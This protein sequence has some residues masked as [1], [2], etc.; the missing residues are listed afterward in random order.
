MHKTWLVYANG[1]TIEDM[2]DKEMMVEIQ[3]LVN[4]YSDKLQ[5][6]E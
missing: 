2:C 4:T 1:W 6:K 3:E 5:I